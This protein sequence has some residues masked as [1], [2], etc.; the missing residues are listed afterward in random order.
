MLPKMLRGAIAGPGILALSTVTW[1]S[2]DEGL[3]ASLRS[4]GATSASS[5]HEAQMAILWV[6]I[7][8]L[9][10]V[11]AL[12][13]RSVIQ[14]RR[15]ANEPSSNFHESLG[16]E[17]IW[18]TIPFVLVILMALPATLLVID[19]E[20]GSDSERTVEETGHQ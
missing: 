14:H 13:L 6:C 5:M 1:P 15:G 12:I 9:G 2:T 20:N 18:T 3:M 7:A 4:G 8:V 19:A 10:L 16:G 17:I 11:F